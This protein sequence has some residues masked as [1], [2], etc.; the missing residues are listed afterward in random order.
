MAK[1]AQKPAAQDPL[2][3]TVVMVTTEH[4]GVFGGFLVARDEAA[5]TCKLKD[6][7]L[8][9][10][11]SSD[12]RGVLGLA[13]PGPTPG[14]RIGYPCPQ[15]DLNAVTATASISESAWKRWESAPWG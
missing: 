8:A 4:R 2:I 14:C 15:L 1:P 9:V 12:C 7:R 6:A 13:H 5:K 10:Y 3:G 11:W